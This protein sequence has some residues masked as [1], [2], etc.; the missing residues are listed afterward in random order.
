T[1]IGHVQA[2]NPTQAI[3]CWQQAIQLQPDYAEAYNN[4]GT[5]LQDAD[6]HAPRWGFGGTAPNG[7]ICM[8]H[9]ASPRTPPGALPLD[10]T[11]G[12]IPL[13]PYNR[14]ICFGFFISIKMCA[15]H[16]SW[17][18]SICKKWRT[19]MPQTPSAPA[20]QAAQLNLTAI[21]HVQAGNPTQ[22]ISCWQQ[23]IQLQPD[24]AEAYN[25]LGTLLQDAQHGE[26]AEPFFRHAV[27]LQ[28]DYAEA[29]YNLGNLLKSLHRPAEAE[30]AYRQAIQIRPDYAEAHNN[31][32]VLLHG[33]HRLIEAEAAYRQTLACQPNDAGALFNLGNLLHTLHRPAEAEIAYR[34]AIHN[35]P[36]HAG[37]H[38]HLGLLLQTE[39]RPAEAEAAYR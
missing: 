33:L 2:G 38:A 10:P 20:R 25:N 35:Q 8:P 18:R 26:A 27:Y 11:R 21:G 23:A 3:S 4:L 16:A 32:G 30:T 37:A 28:P 5:L 39:H 17:T 9:G 24:Y 14:T 29:H 6:R 19:I 13:D 22:A 36:N 1:A 12:I 15:W 34:Q 7:L 31:L